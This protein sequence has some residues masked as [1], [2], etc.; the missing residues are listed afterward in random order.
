MII[1]HPM[2]QIPPFFCT[3]MPHNPELA[4]N[5]KLIILDFDGTVGDT[6]QLIVKTMQQTISTLGLEART[7]EQCAAM[8][9]LP[10]KQT[11]LTLL[12]VDDE[13]AERCADTYQQ[14]FKVNNVPDAVSPFPNVIETIRRLHATGYTLTLASSRGHQS[15]AEFVHAMHL[16]KELSYILGANDVT[17]AK[18]HPEPVLKTL[19]AFRCDPQE[20]LVVGDTSYDIEMGRRAGVR[21]C[22]VTYGNGTREQLQASQADFIIDDFGE[23]LE[24]VKK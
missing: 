14:I 4:K 6:R 5:M 19:E 1:P 10:L 13:T 12:S 21:T 20:A 24:I 3:F 17:H 15:L 7:D 23:L 18:P 22:G 8:I 16:E 9:G 2:I 11:F